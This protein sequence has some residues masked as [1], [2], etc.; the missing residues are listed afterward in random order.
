MANLTR[1]QREREPAQMGSIDPFRTFRDLLRWSPISDMDLLPRAGEGF[2]SPDI[3]LKETS[4]A[5]VVKVDLP[6]RREDDVDFSVVETIPSAICTETYT[7]TGTFNSETDF[8]AKLVG[9]YSGSLCFDCT[10]F[11]R[12]FTGT[13]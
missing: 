5:L 12:N 11:T 13:R 3:D 4:V 7:M 10:G 9:S 2:F 1:R 8:T 6:G